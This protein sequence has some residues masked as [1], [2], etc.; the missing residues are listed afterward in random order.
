M[1]FKRCLE[2]KSPFKHSARL[3]M[4]IHLRPELWAALVATP[5][6]LPAPHLEEGTQ[7]RAE[8]T[9]RRKEAGIQRLISNRFTIWFTPAPGSKTAWFLGKN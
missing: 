3:S 2:T 4:A 6:P 7:G 5:S 1:R 8:T 9:L